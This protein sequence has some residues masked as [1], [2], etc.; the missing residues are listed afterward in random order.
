MPAP[1]KGKRLSMRRRHVHHPTSPPQDS[2]DPVDRSG[3][4]FRCSSSVAFNRH[5]RQRADSQ[6]SR[7]GVVRK[8]ASRHVVWAARQPGMQIPH[9][10]TFAKPPNRTIPG[11]GNLPAALCSSLPHPALCWR[12]VQAHSPASAHRPT[13]VAACASAP[14]G[15]CPPRPPAGQTQV[16]PPSPLQHTTARTQWPGSGTLPPEACMACWTAPHAAGQYMQQRPC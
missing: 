9:S 16:T 10:G 5:Q 14:P 15:S 2:R 11:P 13:C 8:G 1:I 12:G 4:P 3:S 6:S 7:S